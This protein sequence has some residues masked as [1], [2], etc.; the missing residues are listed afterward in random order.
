MRL[1]ARTLAHIVFFSLAACD[2]VEVGEGPLGPA[3]CFDY[4]QR[5][6]NPIFEALLPIDY[7]PD[8]N[9]DAVNTCAASNCHRNPGSAGGSLKITP[10]AAIIDL[11]SE[12]PV[13]TPMYGNF[14]SAK[15]NTDV[16][17]PG[18]SFLLL[19]PRVAVLHGGGRVFF[20]EADSEYQ[21]IL[22][23]VSNSVDNYLS[24]SCV[25]LFPGGDNNQCQTFP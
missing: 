4:Y 11:V 1:L 14:L 5:C 2:Q 22:Y 13:G 21:H 25:N 7:E 18:Q 19:K 23:W 10:G 24:A 12:D 9:I 3:L 6:I 16:T 17:S 8:G 20:S 15:G